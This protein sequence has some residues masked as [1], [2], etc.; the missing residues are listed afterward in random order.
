MGRD[1][2]AASRQLSSPAIRR[3]D[4]SEGVRS[5]EPMT[6]AEQRVAVEGGLGRT[7]ARVSPI[8]RWTD[9]ADG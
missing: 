2:V 4:E 9:P 3:Y 8:V 7:S 1:L 6:A 5:I